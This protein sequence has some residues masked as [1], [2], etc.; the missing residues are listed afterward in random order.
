MDILIAKQDRVDNYA[1]VEL[2][3][4]KQTVFVGKGAS[5]AINVLNKNAAHKAWKGC[6]K[7]FWSFEDAVE[8]YKSP[9]MKASIALAQAYL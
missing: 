8:A 7:T 4:G 2:T 1:S 9:F 6:G 5:G 3:N